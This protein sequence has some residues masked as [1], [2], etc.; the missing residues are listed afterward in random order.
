MSA[1]CACAEKQN[2]SE[3]IS[4]LR[5]AQIFEVKRQQQTKTSEG[6]NKIERLLL[7]S[8]GLLHKYYIQ[9]NTPRVYWP[10]TGK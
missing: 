1:V 6:F 10:Y 3:T 2:A 5:I 9:Y 8:L 7:T 4:E